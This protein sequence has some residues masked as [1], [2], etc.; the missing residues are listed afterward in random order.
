M[1]TVI[2]EVEAKSNFDTINE[3]ESSKVITVMLKAL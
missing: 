3:Q 2:I 1:M